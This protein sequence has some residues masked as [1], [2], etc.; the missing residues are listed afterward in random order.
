MVTLRQPE[1][2]LAV[3]KFADGW[4]IL[5]GGSDREPYPTQAAAVSAARRLIEAAELSGRQLRLLVHDTFGELRD[6]PPRK[7]A[8][9]PAREKG[10]RGIALEPRERP[11][12]RPAFADPSGTSGPAG[13]A[14]H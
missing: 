5:P 2:V 1:T 14:L 12:R 8:G 10:D 7:P 11:V 4:R 6:A 3:I 13:M 9:W